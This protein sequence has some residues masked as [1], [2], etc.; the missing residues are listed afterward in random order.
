MIFKMKLAILLI[1]LFT[2]NGCAP[3]VKTIVTAPAPQY[4]KVD[5]LSEALGLTHA[6]SVV[7]DKSFN[8]IYVSIQ[9]GQDPGDGS[10]ATID[11]D[12][13]IIKR[14]FT[15]GLNNPKGIALLGDWIY[16]SDVTELVR[17]HRQTG[18]ID[19]RFSTG[20]EQF[21]NDVA[22]DDD[23]NVYVSD[24]GSS[25]IFQLTGN[26]FEKWMNTPQLENPNGLLAIKNNL[27]VAAWGMPGSEDSTGNTRGRLL[28]IDIESKE[29]A[30]ITTTPKGNLDG[31]QEYDD[32]RFLVSDWRKGNIYRIS[33]TGD[34][35]L[36]M[37][38]EPSVGDILY[39]RD[40]KLLVLPLNRQ[41]KVQIH[42]VTNQ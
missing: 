20:E 13:N 15:S 9:G 23:N 12:G 42:Q 29:I 31:L 28:K 40:K 8:R 27:Y 39:I 1:G 41:N 22:V 18:E 2:L 26:S 30:P 6:E 17:I 36:F 3:Q 34:V 7:Y 24:M 37:N 38:S 19:R 4:Y 16:V 25:S 32:Y 33:K 21:L 14:Q 35:H 10:I 5:L 11:L